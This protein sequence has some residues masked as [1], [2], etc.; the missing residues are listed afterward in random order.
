MDNC[1]LSKAP[2]QSERALLLAITVLS[3]G[4]TK[5]KIL[6]Q[7]LSKGWICGSVVVTP[8]RRGA[9]ILY[10]MQ[11]SSSTTLASY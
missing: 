6:E 2:C 1:K 7:V 11:A 3:Q 8:R 5:K 10:G 4:G 9:L